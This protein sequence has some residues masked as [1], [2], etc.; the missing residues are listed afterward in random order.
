MKRQTRKLLLNLATAVAIAATATVVLAPAAAFAA[1]MTATT[2]ANVRATPGG[3]VIGT[4]RRGTT[5]EVLACGAGWCELDEGGFVSSSL[6]RSG[7][8][9]GFGISIGTGGV[10]I[11]IGTPRPPIVDDDFDVGEVCFFERT[12]YRGD[13]FCMEEGESMRRLGG[14]WNDEISSMENPDGLRVTLCLER[15]FRY[16]RTYTSS[17]R[18]LG[19]F[20]DDV[21]SIRVR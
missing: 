8:G 1:A 9:V 7:R 11:S 16:C 10:G 21:S 14:G 2:N 4:L 19:D 5:V 6:L 17:A 15:N 3:P 20:S 18:S 13:S 12:R